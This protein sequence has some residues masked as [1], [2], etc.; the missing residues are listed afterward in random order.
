MSFDALRPY[1][2]VVE[3]TVR[4]A[5][6][7]TWA[8]FGEWE[9][10]QIGIESEL[11]QAVPDIVLLTEAWHADSDTQVERVADRLGHEHHR[12]GGSTG[13][14]VSSGIG[15]SSL[16]PIDEVRERP[17]PGGTD[18]FPGLAVFAR[19]TGPRGP[20]HVFTVM[21][22]YPLFASARRQAQVR[23]LCAFVAEFDDGD[24]PTI[25]CG[26]FN[27]GDDS[28]EIRMLSGKAATPVER[29]VFYDS[30]EVAGDGSPGFTWTN[31][32]ELAALS[33]YPNRRFD[34][35][36]SAWPR[37]GGVGHPVKCELLG[38]VPEG[39]P[40]LS[41]HYGVVADLRY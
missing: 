18:G 21:L 6:W 8:R 7:N 25:V 29:L 9:R 28:D 32:N 14:G 23:E 30:W 16:W 4:V 37:A 38:V 15:I 19:I 24:A 12:Q 20:L 2:D 1:G 36:F 5:T 34:Y 10:R 33:L 26:D 17:L 35:V 3:S 27:A 40:E 11:A 31:D 41:D 39:E 13:D 22:D